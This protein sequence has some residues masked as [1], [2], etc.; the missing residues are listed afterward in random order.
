MQN[1][2]KKWDLIS[3]HFGPPKKREFLQTNLSMFL[4]NFHL[5][6]SEKLPGLIFE[7]LISRCRFWTLLIPGSKG[8]NL[9]KVCPP[10]QCL[11]GLKDYQY[12]QSSQPGLDLIKL[13]ENS[14][15]PQLSL[16]FLPGRSKDCSP[17]LLV[18][19]V[20]FE[21]V[22]VPKWFLEFSTLP[23]SQ[24]YSSPA[25]FQYLSL[26]SDGLRRFSFFELFLGNK[27]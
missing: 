5:Q 16:R 9:P 10:R 12:V 22:F 8:P 20:F 7:F 18:F 26:H 19:Q 13:I 1:S 23:D 24:I 21:D 6:I 3:N 17:K 14:S 11:T 15:N 25:D 4:I 27:V 2:K